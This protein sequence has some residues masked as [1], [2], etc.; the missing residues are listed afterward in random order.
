MTGGTWFYQFSANKKS[1][2]HPEL[3]PELAWGEP[4]EPLEGRSE[5]ARLESTITF[6]RGI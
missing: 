4:V 5:P 6:R 1:N 3:R 2:R